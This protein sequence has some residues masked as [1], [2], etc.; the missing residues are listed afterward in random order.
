MKKSNFMLTGVLIFTTSQIIHS[1]AKNIEMSKPKSQ[2][3]AP[4]GK[5]T[6]FDFMQKQW[7]KLP[8]ITAQ[9]KKVTQDNFLQYK[10]NS[11]N[12]QTVRPNANGTTTFIFSDT[13]T[14]QEAARFTQSK[15][16]DG[17]FNWYQTDATTL[18]APARALGSA[19]SYT[20]NTI[21]DASLPIGSYA[22]SVGENA[23]KTINDTSSYLYNQS[24][25]KSV[26]TKINDTSSYAYNQSGAKTA[27]ENIN[28]SSAGKMLQATGDL[29]YRYSGAKSLADTATEYNRRLNIY[30][31]QQKISPDNNPIVKQPV[32]KNKKI[33]PWIAK[34]SEQPS[35]KNAT[36]EELITKV[37]QEAE[38]PL[39]DQQ[40]IDQLYTQIAQEYHKQNPQNKGKIIYQSKTGKQ[41]Q[42][43]SNL[44]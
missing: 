25:A 4:T 17:S 11:Q 18:N 21:I 3:T 16:Q 15:N 33:I 13:T 2:T 44:K 43:I 41:H 36:L 31:A 9:G 28:N 38:K 20:A 24:G 8:D 22:R 35:T 32:I 42:V 34:S 7:N 6:G 19:S 1:G 40:Y 5:S 26:V 10:E 39:P 12:K 14:G 37:N 30:E 27:L 29:I 23:I